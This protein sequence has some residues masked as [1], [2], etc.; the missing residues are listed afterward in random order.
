MQVSG[1]VTQVDP[2]AELVKVDTEGVTTK[3]GVNV[4]Q[5]CDDG[6]YSIMMGNF[7]VCAMCASGSSGNGVGCTGCN[8]GT[9]AGVVGSGTCSPCPKG[10]Y[11]Q[12][13]EFAGACC[14]VVLDAASPFLALPSP[15]R[16]LPVSAAC[17]P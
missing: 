5:D 11:A 4:N 16:L 13:G 15:H 8:A 7:K 1:T 6:R 12:G 10:S 14:V 3:S 9:A 2:L 17:Q